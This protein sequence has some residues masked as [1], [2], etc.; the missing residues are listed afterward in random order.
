MRRLGLVLG[1]V[2]LSMLRRYWWVI[3]LALVL[4]ELAGA[5]LMT[6]VVPW[7]WAIVAA[8]EAAR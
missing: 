4:R 3:P 2:P 1:L 6:T 8:L 7:L 5:V